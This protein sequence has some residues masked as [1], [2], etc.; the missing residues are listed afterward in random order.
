MQIPGAFAIQRACLLGGALADHT[1][2]EHQRGAWVEPSA[3]ALRRIGWVVRILRPFVWAGLYPKAQLT[4]SGSVPSEGP[5]L[6]LANHVGFFDAMMLTV[7]VKRPVQQLATRSLLQTGLLGR[8]IGWMGA[9]PKQ[10]FAVDSS[11]VRRLLRW[12][13]LGAA[14]GVFPEG[15]RSWDGGPQPILPGTERLISLLNIPVVTVRIVN[16]DRQ[17]PRW[18][19][20]PRRGRVHIEID[21]PH[22]FDRKTPSSELR[23]WLTKRISV[24]AGSGAAWP[25]YGKDLALGLPNLVFACPHCAQ[26]DRL[27]ALGDWVVCGNCREKWRV[28]TENELI[29]KESFTILDLSHR[30]RQHIQEEGSWNTPREGVILQSEPME[31]LETTVTPHRVGTGRLR[32]TPEALELQGDTPWR[33]PLSELRAV[34]VDVGRHLYFLGPTQTFEAV[35][36]QESVVKW[37]WMTEHWRQ[38][39]KAAAH[40]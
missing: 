25:V 19:T 2:I 33:L 20:R 30:Q 5:M 6:V 22:Q 7:A 35:M 39:A 17:W 24:P 23:D 10:K 34:S 29:G 8:A 27:E 9:I 3:E 12:A 16:A 13:S 14:V 37:E 26:L 36:P 21:A 18:C 31:L 32:L 15:Q 28:T 38:K 1:E 4:W 11:A 40:K